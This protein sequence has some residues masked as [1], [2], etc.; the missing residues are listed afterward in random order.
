M[1]RR[2]GLTALAGSL[3]LIIAGGCNQLASGP[4]EPTKTVIRVEGSDTMV[5][6][7]QAWAETY[8]L[9]HG[10][11]SVQVLG[12]GSGV[13]IASLI[14]GNCDLANTSRKMTA[15][16]QEATKAKHGV[17][18]VE[19]IVGHDA[20]AICVHKSNPLES[21]SLEELAAIFGEGGQ[22]TQ[23]DQLGVTGPLSEKPIVRVS[24]Q[25]SSGTYAYFR[26]AV[27]GKK[28]DLKLGSI[29][30]SGSKDLVTLVSRTP[31]AIGYSGMGYM[32]DEVKVLKVSKRKGDPGIEPTVDNVNN[33]T[34]PL[35]RPLQIY[36]IGQPSGA[37]AEYLAWIHG[38]EGQNVVL[39]LGYVPAG[40][41]DSSAG[42]PN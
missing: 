42:R 24:R 8:H 23:W 11:V 40:T 3:S 37:V 7:A 13:G 39:D 17:E 29:D 6:I 2:H 41:G 19:H 33:G 20:L 38:P 10:S 16:E 14:D 1:D 31:R 4:D 21:I 12:G 9:Q 26:E 30:Q 18:A 27:L 28:R 22:T 36:T 15:K 34:Y 25:N 5:N 35:S 32:T